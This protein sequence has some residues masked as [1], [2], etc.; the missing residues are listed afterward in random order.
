LLLSSSRLSLN[1][2]DAAQLLWEDTMESYNE[3]GEYTNVGLEAGL[4]AAIRATPDIY[5]QV[6]DLLPTK[7]ADAFTIHGADWEDLANEVEAAAWF[8]TPESPPPD[9]PVPSNDHTEPVAYPLLA[10][11][12]LAELYQKRS[13]AQ[14]H[15]KALAR[16]RDGDGVPTLIEGLVEGLVAV[17]ETV[18]ATHPGGL[19]WGT[20]LTFDVLKQAKSALEAKETG[21][22]TLGIPTG[23]RDLDQM[24]NGLNPGFYVL[25]GAPG[26]GKT[27]LALQWA[28]RCAEELPVLYVTYENSP[29][30]LVQKAICR[31]AGI[32][33]A[34]VDRGRA[35]MGKLLEGANAF[36][37]GTESP[38]SPGHRLAFLE[39]NRR[40]TTAYIQG[41][42][43]HA[44][45]R[46]GASRCLVV[47]D[48]LQRMAHAGAS[49]YGSLRENVSAL[50]LELRELATR[51]DSPVLALSSL[52]RGVNNYGKPTL[53]SLKESGDLEFAADVVLLM[54]ANEDDPTGNRLVRNVDLQV[55]KNRYGEAG[56]K[57]KLVFKP[58]L[59]DFK[60]EV[61]E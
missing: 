17:Q 22:E 19:Q 10:A 43:R 21:R 47:V 7:P 12:T 15:Q 40:T 5:W 1:T 31:M 35:D 18:K 53:E 48:Y 59:G 28:C 23:F 61:R 32:S 30:S 26:V 51:L 27:S 34:D 58:A 36:K 16:L 4:M 44:M 52:S 20:Y 46:V 25:G 54:G 8:K 55:A 37:G 45:S 60:E 3:A 56:R 33:P 2:L 49:D 14:L 29:Q 6:L 24:L 57:V 13:L 9:F 42:A 38:E 41:Q 50:T 11:G 39:G